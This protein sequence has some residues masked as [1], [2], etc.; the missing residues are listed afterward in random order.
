MS[1]SRLTSA[2]AGIFLLLVT[3]TLCLYMLTF[4]GAIQTGDTLRALDALTSQA[5]YGD[6]LMDESSSSQPAL[7]IRDAMKLPL[8]EYDVEER[9]NILLAQPLLELADWL[10]LG[11][12]HSVWLFNAFVTA[13]IVGLLYCLARS[14]QVGE[15]AAAVVAI[16]AALGTNLW[17]Y[18]QTFFREPLSAL[19]LLAG[20]AMIQLGIGRRTRARALCLALAA[21]SMALAM[22]TK[23]STLMALPAL[24]VYALALFLPGE[25]ARTRRMTATALTLLCLF[26]LGI[27]FVESLP[28]PIGQLFERLGLD[29][30]Y[31]GAALRS[32]LFSPGASIWAT[33]PI[34]LLG[35]AGCVMH[36]RHGRHTL[37]LAICLMALG[38][39]VGH[40][41]TTGP[42]WF[43]GLSWPPR[44]LLPALPL[45]MLATAPVAERMLAAGQGRLRLI[46]M[47]LLIYG[48]WIQ[49]NG[50]ALS[51]SHYGEV[52]PAE[53]Q[54]L[55]EWLPGMMQPQFFRWFALPRLWGELGWDFLWLRGGLPL[56]GLSFALLAAATA[57]ALFRALRHGAGGRWRFLPPLLAI[58]CVCLV[59]LNLSAAYLRDPRAQSGQAA[60][61][62]ARETLARMAEPGDALLLT[63]ESYANFALNHFD[64]SEPRAIVLARP[65]AQAASDKQPAL[66]SSNNPY[67]WFDA[68]S[69]RVV[70]HLAA[71]HERLW[72][73]DDTSPFM[74]WSFRP[75]ERYLALHAY[76]LG[77]VE[78]S[79]PDDSVR[80]LAYSTMSAAPDPMSLYFGDVATDLRYG[81]HIALMSV[82]LPQA[83]GY[84]P[85]ETVELSLLWRTDARLERSYTVAAFIAY[86]SNGQPIAQGQDSAPQAGFAP[87]NEWQP[88]LPVWDNRAIRLPLDAR[89]GSYQI[90]VIVY[91]WDGATGEVNRL[92]VTGAAVAG[93]G[94]IGVLPVTIELE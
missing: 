94:T 83:G 4:R 8:R 48:A 47:A 92:P 64:G 26:T 85:G 11:A 84:Q 80:L 74:A 66:V 9:L 31:T 49:F 13:L 27:A 73:L 70:R 40:A 43:G 59:F 7:V 41:L 17:S 36:W 60:L 57:L 55:G 81:S 32:Y 58:G 72:L 2:P 67:D 19:F 56:W 52:L 77:A 39:A 88:G 37:V 22:L 33:S 87:T 35:A 79:A 75:L 25:G 3:L 90:W 78:L 5:R 91:H 30:A 50:V 24:L 76:P 21:A 62:E 16:S 44:F 45:L 12:I 93:A 46:W 54:G 65:L 71:K 89:P 53:A 82:T 42:H 38:Y 69:L 28:A 1:L 29:L 14:M 18:S 34:V 15:A 51:L 63:S 6:W 10:R 68:D 20:F 61:H 23:L 86:A